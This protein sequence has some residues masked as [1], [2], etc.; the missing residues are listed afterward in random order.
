MNARPLVCIGHSHTESVAAAALAA[1]QAIDAINFWHL[2]GAVQ[3]QDGVT[4]LAEPVRARLVAPVFSLVG[5]AVHQD[6]GLIAHPRPFDFVLPENP[7]LPMAAGAEIIPF[8]AIL[9][10]MRQRTQPYLDI[11]SAVRAA[12]QGPVFHME[13][14][15]TYAH[16]QIP[17]DDPGFVAY[18]GAGA[19]FSPPWLRF[20][21]WRVHSAIVAAHCRASCIVFVP[22]PAEAVDADGFLLP[23]FHGT[24]AH[25]NATYGALLLRQMLGG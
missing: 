24:P 25:S 10:V 13:S 20:K 11:M 16:E 19:A 1:G 3:L 23:E 7:G 17:D 4:T 9:S 15:P 21:L 6:V 2:P 22:H 5:G 18:F 8:G 14:P 12:T